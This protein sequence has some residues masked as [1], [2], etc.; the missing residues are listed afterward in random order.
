MPK[1]SRETAKRLFYVSIVLAVVIGF[2]NAW[3][4]QPHVWL[5]YQVQAPGAAPV[6]VERCGDDDP[7]E[8]FYRDG[9]D[10]TRFNIDLCFKAV[11]KNRLKFIPYS[12]DEDGVA[13]IEL[14]NSPQIGSYT[15]SVAR[16][17]SF[18][19]ADRAGALA[20]WQ[21]ERLRARIEKTGEFAI[22]LAVLSVLGCAALWFAR[23]L[24]RSA[25]GKQGS[26]SI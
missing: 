14:K 11:E 22:T 24:L 2:V 13:W 1:I 20:L 8:Y 26:V 12:T 19:E 18:P 7:R 9:P 17:F 4:V 23:R 16:A 3:N 21:K 6:R 10:G 15:R 5:T 25:P